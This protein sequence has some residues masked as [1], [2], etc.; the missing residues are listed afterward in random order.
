MRYCL[1]EDDVTVTN[2]RGLRQVAHGRELAIEDP[3]A[4]QIRLRSASATT[5]NAQGAEPAPLNRRGPLRRVN[6]DRPSDGQ[7]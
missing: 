4:Q 1:A 7:D 6:T 3:V 2:A 5:L